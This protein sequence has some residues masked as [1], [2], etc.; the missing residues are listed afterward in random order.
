MLTAGCTSLTLVTKTIAN[1]AL[2]DLAS[3][4]I[5]FV[6]QGSLYNKMATMNAWGHNIF[7]LLSNAE[8]NLT[9]CFLKFC[10]Q[11]V[12]NVNGFVVSLLRIEDEIQ[13]IQG[14]RIKNY[15]N[16]NRLLY[17]MNKVW[18]H[19]W[20]FSV[21]MNEEIFIHLYIK[22]QQLIDISLSMSSS[23]HQLIHLLWFL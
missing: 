19:I 15:G 8:L 14:Y 10:Q 12:K 23:S 13:G 9:H 18:K 11:C 16:S 21:S 17:R 1:F 2:S 4:S 6:S 20:F 7:L 5:I 22:L 3:L